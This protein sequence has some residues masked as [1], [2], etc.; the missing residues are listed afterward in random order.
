M[1]EKI[2]KWIPVVT[3]IA[4]AVLVG[5][6]L[7]GG[8]Q[9]TPFGGSTADNWNV[10]GN[11]TVA[12]TTAFTGALTLGTYGSSVSTLNQGTCYLRPY[13][14]TVAATSTVAVDCQATAAWNASGMSALTGIKNFT[15]VVSVQLSTTTA[16]TTFGGL[17]IA[18]ASAS[19]TDGYIVL[20][21]TNLTGTTYT[22]PT[23][24]TASGTATYLSAN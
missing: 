14:A 24:G 22:W 12:G 13:A 23:T 8:N 17:H 7:V 3:L 6:A 19:S 16:G 18:G 9:S 2:N 21:I 1:I 20:H 15:D 5:L 4:V 11:L 10:G